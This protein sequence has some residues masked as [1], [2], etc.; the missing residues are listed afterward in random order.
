MQQGEYFAG[1]EISLTPKLYEFIRISI[2]VDN[3]NEP[4]TINGIQVGGCAK[5]SKSSNIKKVSC[6]VVHK[7]INHTHH[8]H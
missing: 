6:E 8:P 3:P 1:E 5:I 2:A 4:I 7:M